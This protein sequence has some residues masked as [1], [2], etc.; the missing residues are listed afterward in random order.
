MRV[1]LDTNV[2]I[3]GLAD[4]ITPQGKLLAAVKEG[5]VTMLVTPVIRRE[6]VNIQWRL[7]R[8]RAMQEKVDDILASAEECTPQPAPGVVIDDQD[9]VKFIEAA[10]GGEADLIVTRDRHLLDVGEVENIKIVSPAEAWHRYQEDSASEAEWTSWAKGLGLLI[11][12]M[13]CLLPNT[14]LAA[15]SASEISA[16]LAE[17]EQAIAELTQKIEALQ[18]KKNVVASEAELIS[19][20]IAAIAQRLKKAE[21]ELQETQQ[22]INLVTTQKKQTE[23][24]IEE[25]EKA[26]SAKKVQLVGLIRLLYAKEQTPLMNVFLSSNSLSEVLAEH[27]A[28]QTLQDKSLSLMQDLQEN[29]DKLRQH[30]TALAEQ[31]EELTVASRLLAAQQ[32]TLDDQKK[33][34]AR[35]LAAK[36]EEQIHFEQKIVEA[37]AA[38]KEVESNLFAL[39]S[40]GVQVSFTNASD[41][42][43][44]A[45]DLTGVRP[46][47]LLAV[48]KVESNMGTNIGSGTFPDDMQ[49]ASREPFL[50]LAKTLGRDPSTMPI[51]RAVSYGWGGAM[52]PAQIMPQTWEGIQP[53]LAVL[54]KKSQPDPYDLTDAFVATALIL[55]DKGAATPSGEREAVGRYLAGP[56][57]QKYPWYIERVFAVAA[58]YAKEGLS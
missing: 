13:F 36:R 28:V 38:R 24:S 23:S 54:L 44:H 16:Q 43:K 32:E 3:D 15:P 6:Y 20:Q 29:A 48:L 4:E 57:W 10:L 40:A 33:E 46:S 39:K 42:A 2:I 1:V 51:S 53:R 19:S 35:F 58:E 52:G 26:M 41:M 7:T 34:Q 8:D 27:A 17:K 55:S 14:L 47:V 30:E 11:V 25:L 5:T 45:S 56:N 21:L 12:T 37:K 22:S 49:P 50:R 31:S 18:Q 9:D